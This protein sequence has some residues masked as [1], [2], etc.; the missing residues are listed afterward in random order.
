MIGNPKKQHWMST[1]EYATVESSRPKEIR[2]VIGIKDQYM[3]E[4]PSGSWQ[5]RKPYF[6]N[7]LGLA[8]YDETKSIEMDR[9]RCQILSEAT[10]GPDIIY[11]AGV[12]ARHTNGKGSHSPMQEW[13]RKS[14]NRVWILHQSWW[15]T[16]EIWYV[17]KCPMEVV[18][19]AMTHQ[20]MTK[21]G[22]DAS[23]KW[24]RRSPRV[25]RL[26]RRGFGVFLGK[27]SKCGNCMR[28]I[29]CLHA[30]YQCQP[31]L[32]IPTTTIDL[33]GI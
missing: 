12:F 19:L 30:L 13:I 24:P 20:Q 15:C 2:I 27:F 31:V 1:D 29:S 28:N 16:Y 6:K 22:D 21:F 33:V 25:N 5:Y 7:S 10:G 9:Y 4:W 3:V 32:G 26:V 14:S 17:L 23:T 11:H 8:W 18:L